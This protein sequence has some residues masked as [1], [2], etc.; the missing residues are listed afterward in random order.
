MVLSEKHCLRSMM[1]IEDQM[2]KVYYLTI[3]SDKNYL[4]S[5]LFCPV[6]C[7][8]CTSF[9]FIVILKKVYSWPHIPHSVPVKSCYRYFYYLSII[10]VYGGGICV[11]SCFILTKLILYSTRG[12]NPWL[13]A[14]DQQKQRKC[15][16]NSQFVLW[17]SGW[18]PCQ[19]TMATHNIS[20]KQSSTSYP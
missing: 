2:K 9:Y 4:S 6:W 14:S 5:I 8:L 15:R 13:S 16:L 10:S 12:P 1:K 19:I 18:S 17:N 3:L 11:L 20:S 7:L